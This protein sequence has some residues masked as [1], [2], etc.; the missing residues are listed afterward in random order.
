MGRRRNPTIVDVAQAAGVSVA[1]VSKVIRDAKGV[2][3]RMREVVN[4]AID[5][6]DYR[7]K[8]GARSMRGSTYTLGFVV[9]AAFSPFFS[10][11][12]EGVADELHGTRY[13]AIVAMRPASDE[14]DGRTIQDLLDRQV[15]GIILVAPSVPRAWIEGVAR[16]TPVVVLA[17]HDESELYDT[18]TGDDEMGAE[19]VM[20][21]LFEL[22]HQDIVHI[23]NQ[24]AGDV[25]PSTPH[26]DWIRRQ[27]YER[28]M[29][30]AGLSAYVKVIESRFDESVAYLSARRL[31]ASG[32]RPSAIF[33]G[34]DEAAFGV[35]RALAELPDEIATSIA[36]V[37]YDNT[38][39]AD[40]P[41]M[42]LTSVD[43]SGR[44]LGRRAAAL[45]LDRITR[46]RPSVQDRLEPRL[47]VRR[48]SVPGP[49]VLA[50]E[51]RA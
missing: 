8:V 17:R 26:G 50:E 38:R 20:R 7:P 10:D 32:D 23:A 44:E 28:L 25:E 9:P 31:F 29:E 18:V 16:R 2:S 35:L 24:G 34:A 39:F 4:R 13:R 14:D 21:H 1:A 41:R 11:I 45:V 3:P 48:S 33:A 51:G 12:Y 5:E 30:E 22:G 43:Q 47:I 36:V 49:I 40:H 15:D 27:T 42:S 6:L 46:R 37:G 19:L